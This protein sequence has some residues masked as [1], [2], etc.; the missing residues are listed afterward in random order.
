[1]H[2]A[3]IAPATTKRT[4][5]LCGT[6]I[7]DF[8]HWYRTA[9]TDAVD[10][11]DTLYRQSRINLVGWPL[12]TTAER[13]SA[14]DLIAHNAALQRTGNTDATVTT[15]WGLNTE[16]EDRERIA[17]FHAERDHVRAALRDVSTTIGPA[18]LCGRI[19]WLSQQG[20]H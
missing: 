8:Y 14:L 16:P 10:R 19:A 20:R 11:L 9:K 1:M 7:T 13:M 17:A 12:D 18:N 15:K 5:T 3:T 4:V 2:L 6:D